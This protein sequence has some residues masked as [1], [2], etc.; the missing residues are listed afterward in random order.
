[1]APISSAI[2]LDAEDRLARLW[3]ALLNNQAKFQRRKQS[4][5]GDATSPSM[6]VEAAESTEDTGAIELPMGI[7]WL[8][9]PRS[10][11]L[12]V[13]PCSW[14]LCDLIDKRRLGSRRGAVVR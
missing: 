3:S 6:E 5:G 8:H 14:H 4:Q 9:S 11:H 1:M 13:R 2:Q 12:F 10:R 7:F